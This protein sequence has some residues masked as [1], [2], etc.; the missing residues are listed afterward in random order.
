MVRLSYRHVRR[1]SACFGGQECSASLIGSRLLMAAQ[2]QVAARPHVVEGCIVRIAPN[3]GGEVERGFAVATERHQRL[4]G[5]K[6]AVGVGFA[7]AF[8]VAGDF[9]CFL[10][11]LGDK[12]G[13]GFGAKSR[14]GIGVCGQ[15]AVKTGKRLFYLSDFSQMAALRVGSGAEKCGGVSDGWLPWLGWFHQA[16]AAKR[17]LVIFG[18]GAVDELDF[19]EG[20]KMGNLSVTQAHAARQ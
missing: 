18:A 4:T 14:L 15:H 1:V 17:P 19:A 7:Q 9:Q 10:W 13:G 8:Q 6:R 2:R 3:G 20:A 16:Q 5:D 12:Q 11:A